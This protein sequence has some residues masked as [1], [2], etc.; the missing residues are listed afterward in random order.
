MIIS[1]EWPAGPSSVQVTGPFSEWSPIDLALEDGGQF[2]ADIE[3]GNGAVVFKVSIV[4]MVKNLGNLGSSGAPG[5]VTGGQ[6][7]NAKWQ[8]RG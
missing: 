7:C 8:V 5:Q 4:R 2:R 1:F 6:R 3:V